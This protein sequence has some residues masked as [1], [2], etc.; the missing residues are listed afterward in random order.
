MLSWNGC[1]SDHHVKLSN[2]EEEEDISASSKGKNTGIQEVQGYQESIHS[3]CYFT[4]MCFMLSAWMD[5]LHI[6]LHSQRTLKLNP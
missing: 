4:Y 1:A 2:K 6:F 5:V 3:C